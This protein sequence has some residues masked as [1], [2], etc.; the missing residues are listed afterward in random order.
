M[1]KT[2]CEIETLAAEIQQI[3]TDTTEVQNVIT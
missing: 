3:T 1:S 2:V